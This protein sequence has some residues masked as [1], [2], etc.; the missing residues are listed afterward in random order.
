[1]IEKFKGRY[2]FLSN[3][4][5]CKVKHRGIEYP[6]VEH[7]YVAQK[8]KGIQHYQGQYFTETDF[9]EL[10]SKVK[11]PADVKKMGSALKLRSDWND[12]KFGVMLFGVE[13]KFSKDE[14]LKEM[15]LSTG[16]EQ[17]I[18]GNFWHDNFWGNCSCDKCKNI[19]GENNLGKILM[20]VREDIR[21]KKQS[22]FEDMINEN[23]FRSSG[24]E[25]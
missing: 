11:N 8:I 14:K 7:Y 17:I 25:E 16:D 10:L 13:Y 5:P 19:N 1:M 6:S 21:P 20:R 18:E 24:S 9:K 4:Y 12:I 3:F 15:L 22:S 23:F 2:Y